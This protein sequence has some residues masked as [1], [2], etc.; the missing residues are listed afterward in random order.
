MDSVARLNYFDCW[1]LSLTKS[2]AGR[3]ACEG[4]HGVF[5]SRARTANFNLALSSTGSIITAPCAASRVD[6]YS[7]DAADGTRVSRASIEHSDL[8][9]G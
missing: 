8:I 4:G 2:A 5:A 3:A 9:F 7:N 6:V 1:N